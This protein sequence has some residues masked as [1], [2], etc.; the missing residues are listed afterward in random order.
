MTRI[1][2]QLEDYTGGQGV[3][4]KISQGVKEP[5]GDK[6]KRQRANV[7]IRQSVQE[8]MRILNRAS[9]SR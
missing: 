5:Y 6:T 3:N 7:N 1:T 8:S 9:R 2:N 4:E